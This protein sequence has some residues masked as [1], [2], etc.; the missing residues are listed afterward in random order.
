MRK[1]LFSAFAV[2]MILILAACST[3]EN[4]AAASAPPSSLAGIHCDNGILLF[5]SSPLPSNLAEL[6]QIVLIKVP[7]L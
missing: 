2:A 1:I 6:R 4:E 3:N 7:P 5:I